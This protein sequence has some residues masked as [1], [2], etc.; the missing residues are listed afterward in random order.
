M[1][2]IDEELLQAM[3]HKLIQLRYDDWVSAFM[4][5]ND[6]KVDGG[7][8]DRLFEGVPAE[9]D[10]ADMY[11]PLVAA[12]NGAQ[13]L[14]DFVLVNT[15]NT[16]RG[17]TSH[18][19]GMYPKGGSPAVSEKLTDWSSI[20]LFVVC[21][22][23]DSDSDPYEEG[24]YSGAPYI[25]KG[26][27]TLSEIAT[28][29]SQAFRS[30]H[31]THHFGVVLLGNSA[32]LG[33]WDRAGI[34]FSS[35]F[36]YKREPE[37]LVRFFQYVAHATPEARG[38]D[39]TATR[40][41]PGSPD[42][43]ILQAWRENKIPLAENDYVAKRFAQTIAV[44]WPWY[45]LTV[46]DS[47]R[48]KME[49]L[50]GQPIIAQWGTVGRGTR[51]HI[52][53]NVSEP[54]T[55]FAFL[56]DCW[57]GV[58]DTFEREGDVLSYLNEKGVSNV[59]TLVCHGDV[60]GHRTVSQTLWDTAIG[61]DEF[62][63]CMNTYHHYRFVVQEVG[64]SLEDFP[65]GEVLVSVIADAVIA[66]EQAY[67]VAKVLHG[68]IS[69]GNI[70]IVPNSDR[71]H[72]RG[73][74]GLLTDW[75]L[76][77][78]L[79][80]YHTEPVSGNHTGTWPFK[81]VRTLSYPGFRTHIQIA[82]ELESF[83]LVMIYC[84]V[85]H[86][87]STCT[88]ANAFNDEFFRRGERLSNTDYSCSWLKQVTLTLGELTTPARELIIFLREPSIPSSDDCAPLSS[89]NVIPEGAPSIPT[90]ATPRT[91]PSTTATEA[92]SEEDELHPINFLIA[93]ILCCCT[94]RYALLEP[95]REPSLDSLYWEALREI[96]PRPPGKPL[97]QWLLDLRKNRGTKPRDPRAM[98]LAEERLAREKLAIQKRQ[99]ELQ[100]YAEKV[101]SHAGILDFLN[102][103][104]VTWKWPS[105]DRVPPDQGDNSSKA[106]NPEA[107]PD[108]PH[109]PSKSRELEKAVDK[110]T[111][112]TD[113]DPEAEERPASKRRRIADSS[114]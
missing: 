28:Y 27:V 16:R 84:A 69:P 95:T 56:K 107:P 9:D 90:S 92:T 41:L 86:L 65:T 37:K 36:D 48:G 39:S 83:L 106:P 18:H 75:E 45:R 11:G 46:T 3:P 2:D 8:Y 20:E 101:E 34:V 13:I 93:D 80:K 70:L 98:Q 89:S 88:D 109:S 81:S 112:T 96:D 74:Q 59:P 97:S 35:K 43:E 22:H 1:S 73:Y 111:A 64:M 40:I 76:S 6:G 52:A 110:R 79:E 42:Y 26:K 15:T 14:G 12:V 4:S 23:D 50:V 33:R 71:G 105:Q 108:L 99:E 78:Q 114:A 87:R 102:K 82:D 55:P 19:C 31:L 47:K 94:A 100:P 63:C 77:R 44:K 68:D 17:K 24:M 57:R 10:E 104:L 66:H 7:T 49:F 51:G 32:R 53:L 72:K 25:D 60:E 91:D 113:S 54:G 30:Q 21:K 62:E 103:A 38:H 29:G 61:K 85:S 67:N 58:D 5:T